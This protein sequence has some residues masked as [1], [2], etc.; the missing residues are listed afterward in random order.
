M[1][2]DEVDRGNWSGKLDFLLSCIGYA[3]GKYMVS[4]QVL[5]GVLRNIPKLDKVRLGFGRFR[6]CITNFNDFNK[7]FEVSE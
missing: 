5:H 1:G 4:K 7:I 3:V 2:S 6:E